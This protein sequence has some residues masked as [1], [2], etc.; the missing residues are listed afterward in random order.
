MNYRIAD[1]KPQ[2]W[3]GDGAIPVSA[4]QWV[5][6]ELASGGCWYGHGFA[7]RQPYPLNAEPVVNAKFAVNNIQSPI[8][9]CSAGFALLADTAQELEVRCNAGG[10]GWLEIRC[11]SAAFSVQVFSGSNLP[12]AH[13]KLMRHLQWPPPAPEKQLLGDSIFC[14]WT[15]YPRAITQERILAMAREIRCQGYPCS[16]LTIDDRWES[17]F[18]ELSFSRDFPDPRA[19]VEELHQMGFRVL[20]WMTPFVNCEAATFPE[21][22]KKSLLAPR[23]DGTGPSLFKWW[24]GT[25][26][27]VDLTNPEGRSWY[28]AQLLRLKNEIGVDGFKIDGGDAKYQPDPAQTAWHEAAGPSGYVD[29]LLALFEEIAPGCCES[30]TAW[31]SPSRNIL[32]REGGK[33]SHWGVDNGLKAVVSLGLHLALLG[34]DT[35]IPDMIPGRIQTMVST[36]PLPTDELFIRWTEVSALMPIM[37]FSYFPWNYAEATAHITRSYAQLHKALEDYL[38]A[39]AQN[40]RASLLRPLWY[41]APERADLYS[42][43][44]EFLLGNDILAAPVMDENQVARD[45]VLPPGKWRDAWTGKV[46]EQALIAQHPAPCPGIPLFVRAENTSLF[47]TLHPILAAI[48]R[49]SIASGITT[50]TY[51]CGLDRDLSVTG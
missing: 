4:G 21:L 16:V 43:A 9:M 46:Y 45:I 23:K 51:A 29:L 20:L 33:D 12:E 10:N 7:H 18:G 49:G 44:D 36:L 14:T 22:A 32:W 50:A 39:Q 41:D 47:E 35:L 2:A 15:Q 38:H 5:R 3:Q 13:G 6:F 42:V 8:W 19:M 11:Q 31:L 37:Q 24:G 26:G 25:A 27:L 30:R 28:R 17:V 34:Y 40:R 48:P 1:Q